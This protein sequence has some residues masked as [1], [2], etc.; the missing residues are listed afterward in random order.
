MKR[1]MALLRELLLRLERLEQ[2]LTTF[3]IP[4]E[5]DEIAVEGKSAD[6]ILHALHYLVSEGM[7]EGQGSGFTADG[8]LMFQ[9]VTAEGHDFLEAIA[10]EEDAPRPQPPQPGS[11]ADEHSRVSESA[12]RIGR[13][14]L[15]KLMAELNDT[16]H[17]FIKAG[18]LRGSGY[19]GQL[20][21]VCQEGFR[22]ACEMAS[23]QVAEIM[24]E[25]AR[26]FATN[27][28]PVLMK[29][30]GEVLTLF[31]QFAK[32]GG[33]GMGYTKKRRRDLEHETVHIVEGVIA[34]LELGVASGQN[35]AKHRARI[36]VNAQGGVANVM[37]ESAHGRITVHGDQRV[38]QDWDPAPLFAAIQD[39][40]AAL[41]TSEISPEDKD[42]VEDQ[43]VALE[44]EAAANDSNP[45]RLR[46]M[47][48]AL[49]NRLDQ[50]S[51]NV[52]GRAIWENLPPIL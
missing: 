30:N 10:E 31:D 21:K 4:P 33:S 5:N 8:A 7:I 36:E 34:D 27:L 37:N 1:D 15:A 9:R 47:G 44:R 12:L 11:A 38:G 16:R 51:M 50:L 2:P 19:I 46:R 42:D 49:R 29:L 39:L 26:G 3:T 43:T 17:H 22:D 41:A 35:V 24:G 32:S 52:L 28:Q 18:S 25:R 48:T 13:R 14:R 6:E 23:V 45:G 20:G 40:R